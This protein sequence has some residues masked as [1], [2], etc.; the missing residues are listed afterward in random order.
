MLG[1]LISVQEGDTIDL[2]LPEVTVGSDDS[3]DVVIQHQSVEPLHCSLEYHDGTWFVE[4]HGTQTG[5]RVDG[6]R[7]DSANIPVYSVLSI[8]TVQF[9]VH[10]RAGTPVSFS[11]H[12][13]VSNVAPPGEGETGLRTSGGR[14]TGEE[15]ELFLPPDDGSRMKLQDQECGPSGSILPAPAVDKPRLACRRLG[16]FRPLDGE[17]PYRLLKERLYLGRDSE[18]DIVVP[19]LNVAPL[20]CVLELRDGYWHIR[21]LRENGIAVDGKNCSESRLVPGAVLSICGHEFSVDYKPDHDAPV[22]N[23][24]RE[25]PET[26]PV[27]EDE[28]EALAAEVDRLFAGQAEADIAAAADETP[29]RPS[30]TDSDSEVPQ[31]G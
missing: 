8:G 28:L 19:G 6:D 25:T 10:Y 20:H 21:N 3:C 14:L 2:T 24:R 27:A 16:F 9:E 31:T 5:V 18:C 23:R 26:L 1:K 13:T 29:A 7:I 15:G 22:S 17:T 30:Q 12:R 11:A 4:D